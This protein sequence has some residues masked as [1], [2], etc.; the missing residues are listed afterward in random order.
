MNYVL[1]STCLH[2]Q[3]AANHC[4][5][6]EMGVVHI[7]HTISSSGKFLEYGPPQFFEKWTGPYYTECK[8]DHL[9][10]DGPVHFSKVIMKVL[11]NSW[12]ILLT[13]CTK[14]T[15]IGIWTGPF[16]KMMI[17]PYCHNTKIPKIRNLKSGFS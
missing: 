5:L 6:G 11:I 14:R 10:K 9:V 8:M 13:I 3:M 16:F 7:T 12:S 17:G 1:F 2:A 15:I 4:S